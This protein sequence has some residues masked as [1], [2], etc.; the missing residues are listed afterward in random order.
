M[1]TG[2]KQGACPGVGLEGEGP[3]VGGYEAGQGGFIDWEHSSVAHLSVMPWQ[4]HLEP[5]PG[6]PEMA[7]EAQT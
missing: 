6:S 2:R 3:G 4:G 1:C 7:L 5:E